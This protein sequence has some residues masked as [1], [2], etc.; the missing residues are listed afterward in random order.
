MGPPTGDASIGEEDVKPAITAEGI[1]Y[2]GLNSILVGGVKLTRADIHARVQGID[3]LLVL[4]EIGAVKVTNVD[5]FGAVPRE[6]VG[7]GAAYSE[8]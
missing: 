2:Y 3:L 4:F 7:R 6:L 5:S 1:I 8:G